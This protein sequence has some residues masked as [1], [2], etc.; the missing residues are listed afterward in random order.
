MKNIMKR[1][2]V[3][4]LGLCGLFGASGVGA[5]GV[6]TSRMVTEVRL[7]NFDGGAII[8]LNGTIPTSCS[9]KNAFRVTNETVVRGIEAA[10]LAGRPIRVLATDSC[11]N[12]FDNVSEVYY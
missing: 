10:Y 12:V 1:S 11:N 9:N 5:A 8:T 4:G 2:I 7:F 3:V 6:S